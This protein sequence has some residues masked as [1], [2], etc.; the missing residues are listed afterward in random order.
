M[1]DCDEATKNHCLTGSRQ[2]ASHRRR[3][4]GASP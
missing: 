3:L 2:R 1:N 4:A